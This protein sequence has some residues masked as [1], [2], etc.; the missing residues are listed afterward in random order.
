MRLGFHLTGSPAANPG[1]GSAQDHAEWIFQPAIET[2]AHLAHKAAHASPARSSRCCSAPPFAAGA[3]AARDRLPAATECPLPVPLYLRHL[4][5]MP[6][7]TDTLSRASSL[8]TLHQPGDFLDCYSVPSTL[9][10]R[11][12]ASRGSRFPAG[13]PLSSRFATP[14]SAPSAS[15]PAPPATPSSRPA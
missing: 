7:R 15:R 14:S 8:W 11:E 9:S 13:L 5:P 6:V 2:K 1:P 4:P 3:R 12:A 10:P